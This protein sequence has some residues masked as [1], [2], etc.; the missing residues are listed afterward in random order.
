MPGTILSTRGI[1]VIKAGHAPAFREH[2][3]W[4]RDRHQTGKKKDKR[5][6]LAAGLGPWGGGG[7][8]LVQAMGRHSASKDGLLLLPCTLPDNSLFLNR[9]SGHSRSQTRVFNPLAHST[10]FIMHQAGGDKGKKK[11]VPAQVGPQS[12]VRQMCHLLES[13]K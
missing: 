13:K 9:D 11:K 12:D 7:C 2:S 4:W 6:T 10:A 3:F 1:T 8:R 5:V